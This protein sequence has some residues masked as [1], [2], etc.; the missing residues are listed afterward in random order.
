MP[1]SGLHLLPAVAAAESTTRDS[2]VCEDPDSGPD[3]PVTPT[4]DSQ[5]QE[6]DGRSHISREEICTLSLGS[7]DSPPPIARRGKGAGGKKK[8]SE[9]PVAGIAG[10]K[11]SWKCRHNSR[12]M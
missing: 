7:A 6:Q 2:I 9:D 8:K 10:G 4:R 3:V 1:A 5:G 12:E 11:A